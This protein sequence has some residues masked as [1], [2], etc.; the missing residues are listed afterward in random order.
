[1][2]SIGH[3]IVE[4]TKIFSIF[5]PV[6]VVFCRH[7]SSRL[8]GH[9]LAFPPLIALTVW[10]CTVVFV[11]GITI[12]MSY[13]APLKDNTKYAIHRAT[14]FL[15]L[16]R[17]EAYLG[18]PKAWWG[19]MWRVMAICLPRPSKLLTAWIEAVWRRSQSFCSLGL[20]PIIFNHASL[21][22]LPQDHTTKGCWRRIK[23]EN[24]KLGVK[25][26]SRKYSNISSQ[27]SHW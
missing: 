1:M 15:R 26:K 9:C 22:A 2:G 17:F 10:F 21:A 25:V 16:S 12:D 23:E 13:M 8:R 19:A 18:P 20:R 27:R 24:P 4:C 5:L 14:F 11:F 3:F 6:V 7:H